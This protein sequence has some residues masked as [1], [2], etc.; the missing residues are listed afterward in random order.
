ML[1]RRR[2]QEAEEWRLQQL[3]S[4][5]SDVNPNLQVR[6]CQKVV[7]VQRAHENGCPRDSQLVVDEYKRSSLVAES[8]CKPQGIDCGL[9]MMSCNHSQA[10]AWQ[11]KAV[12]SQPLAGSWQDRVKAAKKAEKR[13][14]KKAA[15]AT[16]G[17][18]D[19]AALSKGLPT[20][21]HAMLD[22]TSGDVYYGNLST[23]VGAALRVHQAVAAYSLCGALAGQ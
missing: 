9:R 6:R 14:A 12:P 4:G 22:A 18:T 15:K 3:R 1:E 5:A 2:L 7:Y 8:L 11:H 19:L 10:T 13:A 16:T 17:G 20:G 21:W 23:K